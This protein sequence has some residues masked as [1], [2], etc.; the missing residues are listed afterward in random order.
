MNARVLPIRLADTAEQYPSN[1]ES[2][3][4]CMSGRYCERISSLELFGGVGAYGSPLLGLDENNPAIL[5]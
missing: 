4:C 1:D 2:E 5:N 3:N